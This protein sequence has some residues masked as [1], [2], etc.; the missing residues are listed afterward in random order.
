MRSLRGRRVQAALGAPGQVAA[1]IR[2]GVLAEEPLKLARYAAAASRN[3]PV[4]GSEGSQGPRAKPEKVIM[5]RH[6]GDSRTL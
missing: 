1:E 2:I 3:R 6:C 4:N 5:P